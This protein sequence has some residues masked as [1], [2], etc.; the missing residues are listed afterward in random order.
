LLD[1][2]AHGDVLAHL[3]DLL[4]VG[5]ALGLFGGEGLGLGWLRQV[6]RSSTQRIAIGP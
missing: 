1:A 5:G 3:V 6:V 4:S 2:I